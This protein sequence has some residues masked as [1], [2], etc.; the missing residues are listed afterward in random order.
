VSQI[1][2]FFSGS[3]LIDEVLNGCVSF[4]TGDFNFGR[5]FGA[6]CE[7]VMKQAIRQE[8]ADAL[9]EENEQG[10]HTDSLFGKA[11]GVLPAHPLQ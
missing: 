9:V 7:R 10:R 11:V 8:A 1:F 4:V 6:G 5:R 2:L 3:Q